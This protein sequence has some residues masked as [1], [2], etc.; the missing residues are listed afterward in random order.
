MMRSLLAAVPV[1]AAAA[2]LAAPSAQAAALNIRV[3]GAASGVGT[4]CSY[5]IVVQVDNLTQPVL[6]AENGALLPG[7]PVTPVGTTATLNWTPAV[8][9]SRLLQAQQVGSAPIVSTTVT[10]GQGMNLGSICPVR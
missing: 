6:F 1:V 2:V 10:V 9:G 5:K 3:D 7:S 4:T 8:T